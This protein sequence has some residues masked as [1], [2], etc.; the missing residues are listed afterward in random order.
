M[1]NPNMWYKVYLEDFVLLLSD[2]K[3]DDIEQ[4]SK[5]ELETY[6]IEKRSQISEKV[7]YYLAGMASSN[8]AHEAYDAGCDALNASISS[9]CMFEDFIGLEENEVI[10]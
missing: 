2:K 9:G 7:F 10:L 4:M 5:E 8:A 6:I 1:G 3:L